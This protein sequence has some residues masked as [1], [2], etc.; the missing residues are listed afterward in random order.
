V[1]L[2]SLKRLPFLQV[3]CALV[4]VLLSG[5]GDDHENQAYVF[6]VDYSAST[7]EIRQRQLGVMLAELENVSDDAHVVIYRMGSTTEEVFGGPLGDEG[8]DTITSTLMRDVSTSDPLGGTNFARMSQAL[9]AFSKSYG[10][11]GYVLRVLTDGANDFVADRDNL[12]AYKAAAAEVC[13]DRRL[14]SIV[15]YGVKPGFR[16][17]V[18]AIWGSPPSRLDVLTQDQLIGQ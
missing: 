13:A 12:R 17:N 7:A 1:K 2:Y 16:E 4:A 8:L 14:S 5:C 9:Q 15:F 6:V 11:R 10:G 18:R 3:C